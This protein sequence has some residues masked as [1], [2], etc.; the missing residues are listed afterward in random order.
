MPKTAA[1]KSGLSDRSSRPDATVRIGLIGAGAIGRTHIETIA[2][3]AGVEL[4]GIADPFDAAAELATRAGTRHHRSPQDLFDIERPDA[5][6][7][8]TPNELHVPQALEALSRGIPVLVEKP[9][10]TTFAE[11]QELVAASAETGVPVLVGHHRRHHPA[12]A[13]AK[14]IIASGE[15][16]RI[17]AVSATYFLSKPDDYFDTPWHRTVGTGGAFLINLIHE[18][19]L[20]RHLVGEIVAVSAMSSSAVR[21][22][23]VEDTGALAF[24][25]EGGALGS[26]VV[27]DT[28]AGP[29]SWDLTAGDSPRFPAHGV[30]SHRIGGV[31]ASLTIPTLEVWRHDGAP[32][33]T[34]PLHAHR[35]A[36]EPTSPYVRQLAHF[37]DVVAGR[38]EPLVSAHEGARNL[39]VME[40]VA[41]AAHSG[42]TVT[43]PE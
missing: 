23:D 16:G 42:R 8:A 28:A 11:A 12:T 30:E 35:H 40:A 37:V 14:E 7:I 29:W 21:G 41:E 4:A 20:L 32:N 5:V 25:F 15:L 3:A 43:V 36:V 26:L 34:T 24:S 18:I 9:V 31:A 1:Q 22:L 13:R 38:A 2:A 17:A 27:S 10:A 6:I 39:A 33:W 19:D